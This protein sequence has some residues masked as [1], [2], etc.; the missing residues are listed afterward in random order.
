M[1]IAIVP[2]APIPVQTMYAVP[3]GMVFCAIHRNVKLNP[4][5][6]MARIMPHSLEAG[7]CMNFIP[8]GHPISKIPARQSNIQFVFYPVLT[9]NMLKIT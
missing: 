8:M 5:D 1:P 9:K 6:R 2:T 7:Y 3:I 4:L